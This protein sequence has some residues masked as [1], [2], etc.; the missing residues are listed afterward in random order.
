M[1]ALISGAT[2]YI[3]RD[4]VKHLTDN[5][6]SVTAIVRSSSDASVLPRGTEMKVCDDV[7]AASLAEALK[8]NGYDCF[9]DLAWP[10]SSGD[11]RALEDIQMNSA[12][13]S[14]ERSRA[15]VSLGCGR[16]VF[17]GSIAQYYVGSD[18]RLPAN[19][20]YGAAK[21]YAENVSKAV[22]SD[23]GI[24]H[25]AVHL[26][27]TYGNNA[28]AGFIPFLIRSMKRNERIPL[29]DRDAVSDFVH[30]SDVVNGIRLAGEKGK[31]FTSYFI[32]SGEPRTIGEYAE[33]AK[34]IIG[35]RSEL[36]FGAVRTAGGIT[37]EDL[38][39]ERLRNDAGYVPRIGFADGLRSEIGFL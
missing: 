11:D 23:G 18:G 28:Q 14:I 37:A 24:E 21:T 9:Y 38:S 6:Y 10:G 26:P 15:A 27:S 7:D 25:V 3:G 31:A 13:A 8:G 39:I 12:S 20:H 34:R 30:I 4:L 33:T 35:S 36:L 17:T 1:R 29:A 19:D 16:F 22:C 5:G 2:G 32:G